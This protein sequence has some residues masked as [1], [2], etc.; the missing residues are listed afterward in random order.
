MVCQFL[1]RNNMNQRP[2]S[3][4]EANFKNISKNILNIGQTLYNN[5]EVKDLFVNVVDKVV[6]PLK[7]YKFTHED[8]SQFLNAYTVVVSESEICSDKDLVNNFT[9]FMKTLSVIL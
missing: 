6:E 1:G 2:L 3:E 7:Q 8:L 5:K 9:K 4:I